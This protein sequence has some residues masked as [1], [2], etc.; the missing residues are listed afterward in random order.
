MNG[1]SYSYATFARYPERLH[2][3]GRP[4]RFAEEITCQER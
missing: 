1:P 3:P 4:W 2:T